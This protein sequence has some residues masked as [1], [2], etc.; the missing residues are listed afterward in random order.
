M[1]AVVA[2]LSLCL[3]RVAP[4]CHRVLVLCHGHDTGVGLAMLLDLHTFVELNLVVIRHDLVG[5]ALRLLW[6]WW[7]STVCVGALLA[8]NFD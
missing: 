5:S 1:C 7:W 3:E 4:L 2:Q 8:I 6:H